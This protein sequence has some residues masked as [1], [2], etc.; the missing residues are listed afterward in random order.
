MLPALEAAG[1]SDRTFFA[2][3]EAALNHLALR[4][5]LGAPDDGTDTALLLSKLTPAWKTRVDQAI[6]DANGGDL[7]ALAA[8]DQLLAAAYGWPGL[9]GST[10]LASLSGQIHYTTEIVDLQAPSEVTG[11]EPITVTG[12]FVQTGPDGTTSPVANARVSMLGQPMEPQWVEGV[13]GSDGRFSL[14]ATHG[15]PPAGFAGVHRHEGWFDLQLTLSAEAPHSALFAAVETLTVP[16]TIDVQLQAAWYEDDG[17]SALIGSVVAAPV[18]RIVNLQF[19]VLKAGQPLVSYRPGPGDVTLNGAGQIGS[20]SDTDDEG[21]LLVQY[22][23]DD[24]STDVA[25]VGLV[26]RHEGSQQAGM[27]SID[28]L[29]V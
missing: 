9:A 1:Q 27:A 20:V 29:D 11:G 4:E 14:T 28:I 5:Q 25:Y 21:L 7:T 24:A 6:A 8:F 17:S 16:G 26:V 23:A 3:L 15:V 12:R 18:G 13:T 2:A 10:D 19:R 22:L